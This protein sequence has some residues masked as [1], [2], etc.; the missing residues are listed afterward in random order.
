MPTSNLPNIFLPITAITSQPNS[1]LG[2]RGDVD[3][4]YLIYQAGGGTI[5]GSSLVMDSNR[6]DTIANT[7]GNYH[8]CH[9]A[10]SDQIAYSD[11]GLQINVSEVD[12]QSPVLTKGIVQQDGSTYLWDEVYTTPLG[13]L[14]R[15]LITPANFYEFLETGQEINFYL[16]NK[17]IVPSIGDYLVFQK[18]Y[19]DNGVVANSSTTDGLN[20]LPIHNSTITHI[21]QITD[22]NIIDASTGNY[23]VTIDKDL[24]FQ[25]GESYLVCLLNRKQTSSTKELFYDTFQKIE[26]HR[27]QLL[28]DQYDYSGTL[29]PLGRQNHLNYSNAE[30][31]GIE[32]L[33][34]HIINPNNVN[35]T[36]YILL[37]ADNYIN[38]R[39]FA[40]DG[41][42]TIHLPHIL[43]NELLV[44]QNL[45]IT[46]INRLN[47][48]DDSVGYYD[49]LYCVVTNSHKG[50]V[51][52]DLRIAIITDSELVA[53]M[54]YNSE[55]S[56]T[57]PAMTLTSSANILQTS[58]EVLPNV[59]IPQPY[60]YF[61]TYRLKTETYSHASLPH[62]KPL[63]FNWSVGGEIVNVLVDEFMRLVK[64]GNTTGYQADVIEFIIGKNIID[65]T[66]PLNPIITGYE[67][68]VVMGSV[69]G[70]GKSM[71]LKD[72]GEA[73]IIHDYSFS[74]A[75][76]LAQVAA[77]TNFY[78][79][80]NFYGVG[81]TS[82]TILTANCNWLIGK[83]EY[84][85]SIKKFAMNILY[86]LNAENWN[87]S[88]NP[89]HDTSNPFIKNILISEIGIHKTTPDGQVSPEPFIF[90]KVSP[91]IIK[92]NE[93]SSVISLTLDF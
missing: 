24:V 30:Y 67:D 14:T 76:Y 56:F 12:I 90:T 49:K 72:L 26:I 83:V 73:E 60:E 68:V 19:I 2:L 23:V 54:S 35:K 70:T 7:P 92:N 38:D 93:Q 69:D 47:S 22:I 32:S 77:G 1:L 63:F 29:L 78:T 82:S 3:Y 4:G 43:V 61:I 21:A 86:N 46:N 71:N 40:D 52:Y 79:L 8:A 31:K 28:G 89:S 81:T 45:A 18:Y 51:F 87:G 55:R 48:Y 37:D 66:N 13:L 41:S 62:T 58:V 50:Y 57:L 15:T 65:S 34:G 84:Y 16:G 27:E 64:D 74:K 6:V 36:P 20:S 25:G 9:T 88:S 17:N 44:G 91:P 42:V 75:Q 85:S 80:T 33:V 39:L 53:A 11:T 59:N 10:L 5:F